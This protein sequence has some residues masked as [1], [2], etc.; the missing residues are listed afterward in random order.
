MRNIL[1]LGALAAAAAGPAFAQE[2]GGFTGNVSLVSDYQWRNVTQ[3]NHDMTIQ[4]G[5]DLNA[6]NGLYIGTWASGI[7]FDDA[8][9]ANLEVDVYGG[10]RFDLAGIGVDVGALG[11][12]YPDSETTDLD[13]YEVYTKFSRSFG[14][15]TL[16]A[17]AN[18]NPDNEALYTDLTGTLNFGDSL[19]VSAN[20]GKWLE[21]MGEYTGYNVGATYTFLGT[22]FGARWY[23]NDLD[24]PG[25][26][27]DGVVIS[28][29]RYL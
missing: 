22:M 14:G 7:D 20:V 2:A 23:S 9:D 21:G 28:I 13:F 5:I 25:F 17:S 8:S 26:D 15:F 16:G 3:S 10:Y 6:G 19:Q 4:G 12:F 11:Y 29:G 1:I 27:Q 18:Y 24:T